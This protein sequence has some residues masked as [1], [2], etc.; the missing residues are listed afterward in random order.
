MKTI[1]QMCNEVMADKDLKARL[2]EAAKRGRLQ[3]FLKDHGC[4][5]TLQEVAV[6]LKEKTYEDKPLAMDELE[7][8]SGGACNLSTGVE[9]TV[10]VVFIGIGCALI[11]AASAAQGRVGQVDDEHGRLCDQ[12]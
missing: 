10:S 4:E 12:Y 9:T 5:A 11:A 1:Q 3:E 6:F 8:A 7:N 2:I